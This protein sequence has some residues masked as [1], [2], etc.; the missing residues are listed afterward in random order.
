LDPITGAVAKMKAASYLTSCQIDLAWLLPLPRALNQFAQMQSYAFFY[1]EIYNHVAVVG[2]EL[3][4]ASGKHAAGGL[5]NL[6][7]HCTV[8]VGVAPNELSAKEL[9]SILKRYRPTLGLQ[10][11]RIKALPNFL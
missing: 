10:N 11:V 4:S 7:A 8:G 2:F 3:E 5:L 1:P 6:A 9:E